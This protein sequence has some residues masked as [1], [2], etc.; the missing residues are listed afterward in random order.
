MK[1][2]LVALILLIG[3]IPVLASFLVFQASVEKNRR[4]D[5]DRLNTVKVQAIQSDVTALYDKHI[6]VLKLLARSSAVRSYDLD[7]VKEILADMEKAYPMFIPVAAD[8]GGRQVVKT[9]TYS[10]SGIADR[11]FYIEA[12]T[13]REE[14]LSEVVVSRSTGLSTV[15]LATPIYGDDGTVTGVMQ[16]SINLLKLTDFVKER[17]DGAVT[18]FIVDTEGKIMAHP[19]SELVAERKDVAK[20]AYFQKG[21]GGLSGVEEVIDDKGNK[22]LVYYAGEKKTGW[23][24]CMETPVQMLQ[25]RSGEMTR[26]ALPVVGV[27]LLVVT[28][29]GINK[30]NIL[31]P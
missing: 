3:V 2:K 7:N 5:F 4:E 22:A 24:V 14:V 8:R 10:M 26:R 28:A 21:A 20:T 13:G 16:G 29:P 17:T 6:A 11:R 12:M 9:A 15:I 1:K 30:G 31:P 18:A 25:E 19:N 27:T 23:V